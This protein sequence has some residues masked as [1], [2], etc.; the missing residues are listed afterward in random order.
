MENTTHL[1]LA[2]RFNCNKCHDH[3]FERWTQDQYYQLSQYFAQV[4]SRRMTPA[5]TA[6]S[7]APPSKAP[8]RSSKSSPTK[9]EGEVKHDRTG[10]IVR[11][12]SPYP[13]AHP[14]LRARRQSP[15][16]IRE[17]RKSPPRRRTRRLDDL[18]RQPLL[19]LSATSTASGATCS[20]SAS[21][22]R[23]TTSAPAIRPPTPNCSTISPAS[24]SKA[25]STSR[26]ILRRSASRGPTNSP[27]PP[28]DGTPT[29]AVNFSHAL[30]RR[31]PA[32][33]LLDAVYRV[34][35]SVP[36]F[37]GATRHPRRP[38]R[39]LRH[40]R[41]QRF[42]RQSRPPPAKAPANANAATTSSSV[43][44]CPCSAGP[45]VS[46]PSRSE[47]RPRPPRHHRTD[48]RALADELFL[49]TLNRPP[50]TR[51]KPRPPSPPCLRPSPPTHAAHRR[52]RR[53]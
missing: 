25:A 19:R 7:A 38:T 37:P 30:P 28:T 24:S 26:H 13:V 3:P 33:V 48:D 10:K 5:A 34:T 51:R 47:K 29:T 42:P 14:L 22:N 39:R 35:G 17:N 2:T 20:A 52:P 41:A 43:P 11:P 1:F 53:T 18:P 32:E 31:L 36:N 23:S 6:A 49:R 9:T 45:A 21:S 16:K 12:P 46:A 4:D 40:R 50:P 8:N 44:S 15:P 27:S